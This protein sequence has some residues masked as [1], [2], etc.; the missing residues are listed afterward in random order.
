M[1][2]WRV[3]VSGWTPVPGACRARCAP[4]RRSIIRISRAWRPSCRR[5]YSGRGSPAAM[6]LS[7]RS[8]NGR[9]GRAALIST[10]AHSA[11][12]APGNCSTPIHTARCS[13]VALRSCATARGI[14]CGRLLRS[15]VA[16]GSILNSPMAAWARRLTANR[17]HRRPKS[18]SRERAA[19][20]KVPA[21]RAVFS[22]LNYFPRVS[23]VP[24]NDYVGRRQPAMG[25]RICSIATID[26]RR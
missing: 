24:P 8:A 14:R 21:G 4:M 7:Y 20:D 19:A 22:A 1:N 12:A 26:P 6:K 5:G 23:F 11:C 16:C 25:G 13:S 18:Q 17:R 9:G 2:C 10:S 15:A 3:R